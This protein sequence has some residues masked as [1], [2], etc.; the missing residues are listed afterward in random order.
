MNRVISSRKK[1]AC[2]TITVISSNLR[3]DWPRQRNLMDRMVSFARLVEAEKP[4]ILLLQE[5]VRKPG[6]L[7]DEWLSVRLGMTCVYAREGG[8][9]ESGFEEGLAVMSRYPLGEPV[10]KDLSL[11]RRNLIHNLALSVP[12][13]TPCG[14]VKAV[15]TRL[16]LRKAENLRK[17]YHLSDWVSEIMDQDTVLVGGGFKTGQVDPA[18]RK[19]RNDWVE[20]A[21]SNGSPVGVAHNAGQGDI[22][23]HTSNDHMFLKESRTRWQ[24]IE[25]RMLEYGGDPGSAGFVLFTVLAPLNS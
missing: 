23:S 15:S 7:L 11:S 22:K 16:D 20:I 3:H 21:C 1:Q 18:I 17:I 25:S 6:M 5:M 14:R 2:R 24:V 13:Q 10:L 19:L 8:H 12:V 4:D 9:I